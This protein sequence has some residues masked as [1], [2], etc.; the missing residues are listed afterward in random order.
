M[1]GL[2]DFREGSVGCQVVREIKR[3]PSDATFHVPNNF[4]V[5][6]SGPTF[7]SK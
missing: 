5:L 6:P 3:C 4:Y 1:E 2:V 7:R